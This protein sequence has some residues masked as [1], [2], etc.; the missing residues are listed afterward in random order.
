M[1]MTFKFP[2]INLSIRLLLVLIG[3]VFFGSFLP[4][5]VKSLA[6]AISITLKGLLLFVL[7]AIIFSCLFSCL[8]AFRGRQAIGFMVILF[9]VV[10]LS[11]YAATLIA[12]GVGS[13]K[14]ISLAPMV[15][16]HTQNGHELLPMWHITFPQWMPYDYALYLG[17]IVGAF[18]SFFP[19]SKAYRF[20]DFSKHYVTLF[21]EKGFIPLLPFFALGFIIKMQ[22]DGILANI[23]QSYVPLLLLIT[24]TCVLYLLFLFAMAANFKV[25]RWVQYLKNMVPVALMGLSTMSSLAT[26]P[27]TLAAAEKNTNNTT[28]PRAV[29]PATVNIHMVGVAITIPLMALSIL[30]S[31]GYELPSLA[32]YCLFAAY[33]VLAQFTI[34]AVPGGGILVMLP[35]LESHLGFSAEMTALI[36]ALYILFDPV[37]TLTNVLGNSAL[38][39][40]L[41]KIFKREEEKE[42]EEE[43]EPTILQEG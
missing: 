40:M 18:F 5:S 19:S 39:I 3:T 21:L 37:I 2:T 29:I 8:L 30:M 34:A 42:D 28:I 25:S 17:F 41:A 13:F 43:A 22:H 27:V 31:F 1:A 32:N 12:Y 23:I 6:F 36:T 16:D 4:E 38:V 7:P 33:F 15:L 10:F 35:L 14:L 26:M 9:T 11:N 20:S 24:L